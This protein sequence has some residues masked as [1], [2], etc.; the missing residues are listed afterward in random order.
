[1][2]RPPLRALRLLVAAGFLGATAFAAGPARA[3]TPIDTSQVEFRARRGNDLPIVPGQTFDL[4]VRRTTGTGALHFAEIVDGAPVDLGTAPWEDGGSVNGVQIEYARLPIADPSAGLHD[5]QAIFDANGTYDALTLSVA[6]NVQPVVTATTIEGVPSVQLNHSANLFARI[7][8]PYTNVARTGT[9]EWRDA[10][11]DIVLETNAASDP[12]FV[13]TPTSVGTHHIEVEYSGDTIHLG[14]TSAVYS[15]VVVSDAVEASGVGI[16]VANF[17]PYKDGYRDVVIAKG[18]RIE[19]ASVRVSIH[20]SANRLVRTLSTGMATGPYALSW[21]GR[22]NAGNPQ[23]AGRYRITQVLTDGA[24]MKLTV[25][26]FVNLSL[27][28]L[29]Y[30]T[31]YFTKRGSS[32]SARGREGTGSLYIS[33]SAGYA[34]LRGDYPNGWAGV[35]YQFTLPS[36]TVYRSVA[37]QAHVKGRLSAPPNL[38]GMQNFK[39]CG[40]TTAWSESCFDHWEAA[41]VDNIAGVGWVTSSGSVN[42]NLLGRTV[43]GMISG[44]SG[45]LYVYQV[46]V[47]VVVGVLR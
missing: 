19:A 2:P 22:S 10:D 16:D 15:L 41:G 26:K 5:Y 21:N 35:G 47:K 25:S 33:T 29:V 12:T 44:N 6:V 8:H 23:P 11:T 45:T 46:R 17:Y 30:S 39:R 43:R 27:K 31:K 13:F 14:S 38:I 3:A 32:V 28:R 42:N 24:G 34:R 9:L 18:N 20:N 7:D 37:F 4:Q 36:A 1:M 40:L